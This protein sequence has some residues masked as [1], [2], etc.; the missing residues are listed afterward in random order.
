MSNYLNIPCPTFCAYLDLGFR[1]NELPDITRE[2]S[3]VEVFGVVSIPERCLM[4]TC[5]DEQ[6]ALATRVPIHYLHAGPQGGLDLPLDWIE[7]W[8]PTSYY[9]SV[10]VYDYLKNRAVDIVLKDG[11]RHR[12]TYKFTIDNCLGPQY[13]AGYGE[14][15]A[16]HKQ[17]HFIESP[18]RFFAQPANRLLFYD[19]GS[20]IGRPM[21]DDRRPSDW[22]VF[23]HEFSCEHEAQ[24]WAV[25]D[26]TE[27][28]HYD[29]S[30]QP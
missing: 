10:T 12:G 16:G 15:A 9:A 7:L 17:L 22:E 14:M 13:S 11:T 6:G 5:I 29:F 23:S 2:R 19:G 26:D 1:R 8:N 4:F 28:Y 30:E 25:R 21:Q 18:D 27:R 20:F 3:L 24:R